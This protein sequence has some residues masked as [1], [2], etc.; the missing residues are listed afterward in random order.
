MKHSSEQWRDRLESKGWKAES[1]I[2]LA[3]ITADMVDHADSGGLAPEG[4][5]MLTEQTTPID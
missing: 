3:R 2:L 1:L 5:R 4:E